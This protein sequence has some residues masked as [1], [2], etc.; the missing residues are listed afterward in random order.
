[1]YKKMEGELKD[2]A[3]LERH[4]SFMTLCYFAGFKAGETVAFGSGIERLMF[5]VH[6]SPTRLGIE[7]G[8]RGEPH[9]GPGCYSS[10]QVYIHL[11]LS[12]PIICNSVYYS[13]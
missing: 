6:T 9:R 13:V 12:K 10:D 1:M 7:Q 8:L 3:Y 11:D 4:H 5:P 2:A